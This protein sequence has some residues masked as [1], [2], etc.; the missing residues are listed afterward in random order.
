MATI[1]DNNKERNFKEAFRQFVEEQ[2]SGKAPDIEELVSKYPE[3][4]HQV[5]QKVKEFHKVDSLFDSLVRAEES[6]FEEAVTGHDLVGKNV[7]SFEIKKII[8]R[9]GMGVVYL[10]HDS[11]L[12]RSV[13]IKSMP[14]KLQTSS[15]A[16]VRFKREAKLLASLNHPNIAVIHDI[17]EENNSGF[18]I[19][20][21]IPGQTLA[22]RIAREPLKLHEA[23]SIG[24]QVA[25]AISAAHEKG[26]VHRDL[27]PGNIKITPDGR[28]KVLDFGL[29]KTSGSEGKHLEATVT[30]PGRVM[31]TPAY[32][33]P[34]QACSKQIDKRSDI[35]SLGCIMYE[36]L[37]GHLPFDG[38]TITEILAR[39]IEREPNWEMLPEDTPSNIRV[40]LQRCLEKNPNQRLQHIGDVAIEIRETLN[41]PVTAPPVTTP[42][43]TLLKTQTTARDKRRTAVM[44]IAIA[45]II[46]SVISVWLIKDKQPQSS[47]RD[48]RLVVLPF[49]YLGPAGEE[50]FT[51]GLTDE[52]TTHLGYIHGLA[53]ISRQSAIGFKKIGISPQMVKE[54]NLDYFL[55]GTVQYDKV[56]DPNSPVRIRIQLVKAA[57]NTQMWQESFDKNMVNIYLLQSDIAERVAQALNVNLFQTESQALVS[58]PI[59]NLEAHNLYLQGM[60]NLREETPEGTKIGLDYLRQAIEKDPT[61]PLAYGA[62]ALGYVLSTHGPGAPSDAFERANEYAQQALELDQNLAE[63][64][65]ALAMYKI[66][67]EWDWEGASKEFRTALDLNPNL[68]LVRAHYSFYLLLFNRTDDALAEMRKIQDTDPLMPLWPT[69]LAWQF[70][71]AEQYDEALIEVDKALELAPNFP[72]ALYVKGCALAGNK[73]YEQAIEV[74]E[75]AGQLSAEWKCGLAH[76]YALAGRLDEARQALTELEAD[77]SPWDRWFIAVIYTTLGDK[78]QAFKWLEK[79]YGPPNHPYLPWIKYVPE[80][81][82]LRNDPRFDDLLRRMN[83]S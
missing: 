29:A 13:A 63:A 23:L 83:L 60:F 68:T 45:F 76:T 11:K 55:E 8:G 37:T 52:I 16:Q 65:A 57:D 32:M 58:R 71:W 28:V 39:I 81:K 44:I 25:E 21:Y 54:H 1:D 56:S 78:D 36:M 62:L 72:L 6:D 17:I 30:Q 67:R 51:D 31:G 18:L 42:S 43:S 19:L 24:Q 38:E 79:A 34:E 69:Y 48:K 27:K 74:H 12:G 47:P 10:A 15:T 14:A 35:W 4:E 77:Y 66:Y 49:D 40:L 50:W 3:H 75:K 64:H 53:V 73:M 70:L 59:E 9:G 41:T 7:G 22:E 20:E 26:I 61:D 80:F 46:I 82:S 33:S 5:R 2:L